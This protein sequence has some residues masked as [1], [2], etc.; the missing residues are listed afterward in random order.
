MPKR[1]QEFSYQVKQLRTNQTEAEKKLW[2]YL[3]AKRFAG[4][5]FKRQQPIDNYIADF[6]CMRGRLIIEIDGGHHQ[7]QRSYDERRTIYL[8]EQGFRVLRFWNNEVMSNID[9]VLQTI[10]LALVPSP[11]P[12]DRAHLNSYSAPSPGS[13]REGG[14]S[15]HTAG[16]PPGLWRGQERVQRLEFISMRKTTITVLREMKKDRRKIAALTC[17]DYST[18]QL[19]NQAG[20]DIL[21]I[22]DS[23]GM[24]KL[25]YSSTLPVTVEDIVY[26]T[27]IVSR[28]NRSA[29]LVA[30]MPFMSYQ[31]SKEESIRNAGKMLK[32]GAEAVKLEGG[33][34]VAPIIRALRAIGIPVMG[35]IGMTPQSVNAF[36]GYKV[37]GRQKAQAAKILSDAK[38]VEKAGAFA[39][40][41]ECVPAGL[42]KRITRTV[43]VPVIGIGAGADCDG[44]VLVIDDLLG[45]SAPPSP[46][47]VKRYANLRDSIKRAAV[48][49]A[50]EVR[51]GKFPDE[52]HS[53]T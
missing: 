47:F 3:R 10:S 1:S 2:K 21:L 15:R 27:R 49:Y 5:K 40:V 11:F 45:L 51:T 19:L 31:A 50:R 44:Q 26:H 22:G 13:L 37:Q 42:A 18:A 14:R 9:A 38:V 53:Y 32:A 46:R 30:D 17:Y 6:C 28:G 24:V 7:T 16:D 52:A 35:H 23:L 20:I 8:N 43:K 12:G 36:G 41:L 25:G 4:F 29:L 34:E 33:V 48:D 39:I